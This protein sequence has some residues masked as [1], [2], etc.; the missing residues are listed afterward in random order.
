M[1]AA[2]TATL[3][4]RLLAVDDAGTKRLLGQFAFHHTPTLPGQGVW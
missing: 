2:P 4:A 1:K 3:I